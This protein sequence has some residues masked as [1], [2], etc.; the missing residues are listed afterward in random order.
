MRRFLLLSFILAL[1]LGAGCNS[2][3][4]EETLDL[5]DGVSRKTIDTSRMGLNS[6]ANKSGFGSICDQYQEVAETLRL[7]RVRILFQWNDQVQ[8]S[9]NAAINFS[10][11]DDIL[12]CIPDSIQALVVVTGLPSWM[13]NSDN[14][15]NGN[16]RE[17]F[18]NRWVRPL[19]QRYGTHPRII[20]W[21]IWNEPNMLEDP[22][23]I[24]LDV[25]DSPENYVELLS[26]ANNVIRNQSPNRLLLNA[27]TTAINQNFPGTLRYNR[28]LVE[29]GADVLVDI[30][31]IH[32]YGKQFERVIEDDGVRD[33][34]NTLT[35]PIW[36]T[37][38]GAQG[39]NEQLPY[40][41]TAWPFLREKIPG[42][43]Y[44]FYYQHTSQEPP[45]TS[46]GL[47]NLSQDFPVSDL[48]VYLRDR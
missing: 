26:R 24:I 32:Y 18:V 28:Q 40:V 19:A 48:Y 20:A 22:Q 25:A 38:S 1:L 23:N 4:V 34:L 39:V 14:W 17:T 10:F 2:S 36:I 21:Q 43:D 45:N 31:A 16:P 27:S 44:I 33:F 13:T 11:Y 6:F 9:P 30:W 15:V 5:A 37:E 41:E 12:S 47:R 8:S 3:S 29:A 35:K 7:D 42:I 46:Y